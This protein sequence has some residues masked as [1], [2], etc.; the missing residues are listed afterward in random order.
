MFKNWKCELVDLIISAV[1]MPAGYFTTLYVS[2][3]T[4]DIAYIFGIAYFF[5]MIYM[6]IPRCVKW[7]E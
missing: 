5:G 4:D 3:L 2:T 7:V 6:S 1:I